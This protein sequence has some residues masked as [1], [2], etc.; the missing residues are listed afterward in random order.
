MARVRAKRVDIDAS[1]FVSGFA[2]ATEAIKRNVERD[3]TQ[4][5]DR[6]TARVT[7]AWPVESG[8]QKTGIKGAPRHTKAGRY[9]YEVRIPFPAGF[10]EFGTKRQPPRPT[11]RREMATTRRELSG[12]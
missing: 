6:L 12:R 8:K 4:A 11:L 5:G 10:Y 9:I 2:S 3:F 7:A 1:Q